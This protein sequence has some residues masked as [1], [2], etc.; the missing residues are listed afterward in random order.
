MKDSDIEDLFS[1]PAVYDD[2]A[3]FE[4]RVMRSLKV[5]LWLRQWLVVL[6]GFIGGVYAL[7]QLVRM[8]DLQ[9]GGKSVYGRSLAAVE[10]D[11][12]WRAGVELVDVIRQHFMNFM[13][14]SAQYLTYMQTPAFFW[15]TFSLCLAIVGVYYAYSQ[16]ETI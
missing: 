11:E 4:Q 9:I 2:S 8:P 10:S 3:A 12:T 1:A 6:A 13:D 7:A 15:V 16:E 5:K 14:S